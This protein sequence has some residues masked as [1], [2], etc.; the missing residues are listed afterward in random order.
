MAARR[1]SHFCFFN[2]SKAVKESALLLFTLSVAFAAFGKPSAPIGLLVNGVSNPLAIDRD[3]TRFTWMS[4]DTDRGERQTAYE[5]VVFRSPQSTVHSPESQKDL[6]LGTRDS[7]LIWWDSGRVDSDKSAAV[8]YTGK[9]LPATTRFW[10]KVRIWDQTGEAGNFSEAN[11]F[12]TG[13]NQD[14]WRAKYIW[15]GTTNRNNYA[16][17]RKTFVVTNQP[18]LA[19]VYVMAHND[20]LLYL[21]G[22]PLGRG[23]ARCDPYHYGQYNG[24]DVTSLLKTGTNV[25]AAMGHWRNAWNNAGVDAEPTF[26]LEARFDYSD[27]SF[28]TIG[29][30]ESWKALAHTA[31]DETNPTNSSSNPWAR[32]VQFDSR[33]EPHGWKTTSFDDSGWAPATVVDRSNYHLFAQMAPMEREQAA[34][35]PVGITRTNG[36]WLVDFGRCIDGWP[37]LTMRSNRPG[38]VVHIDYFQMTGERRI[39]GWDEYT[40][41]GGAET[42]DADFGR[43]TSFQVLKISGYAG[44]LRASDVRGM[45]AYCDADVEGRFRC[46]SDLLNDIYKMCERSAR[47]NIQQG[48]IS[49]DANREQAPWL[50]DSWNI[51]NVLLYN[52]R[53]TVMIDKVV[54]DYAGEQFSNGYFSACSPGSRRGEYPNPGHESRRIPEWHMYWPMLLW[55]QYLFSGDETLLREMAPHLARGMEWIKPSQDPESKLLNPPGWRIS[56]Y[57]GGNMPDG[58]FNAATACQYYDDLLIASKVFS[59]LGQTNQSDDYLQQAEQVKDGINAHLFN[60]EYYLARTDTEK[61]FPLASA[62]ALRFD[63]EPEADESKI[64]NSI[65]KA[66]T[67]NIGGYGGDAFYSG[68]F[69]A[70]GG[71]FA[72]KDLNR[73]RPML[74]E[75][76]ACWEGFQLVRG[77]QPNHA[78][79]SYPAYIFPKYILGIQPT[80]GGFATFDVRPETGGLSFAEGAVPTVKGL[81][82]TRWERGNDGDFL[83]K[84]NVPANTRA[85]IYIPKLS[86][87]SS[88]ITES[89]KRIWPAEAEI[90]DA[91]VLAVS[92]KDGSIKCVVGGGEYHFKERAKGF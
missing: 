92:N 73:Y 59:V 18:D 31:F 1:V 12:D 84:V 69:N 28:S 65:E 38:D 82:T 76:K 29:T 86:G 61:M 14:E 67:P 5:I 41:H 48:I 66:G 58:G 46:S 60:G 37:K 90:H 21:N 64:L 85:S 13:L 56:D 16:Y 2:I 27:G 24:Y 45:W 71:T 3:A 57:A 74:E 50:A 23:P 15:D 54:R 72:I 42:W 10:W 47:Q 55:Q 11:Y 25:F 8:E 26:L 17:F 35:K 22:Q 68:L 53:D 81:I 19:K 77:Y 7:G 40:C 44:K 32:S 30:D 4:T 52:D 88:T 79:T 63:I 89:G 6:G 80:S 49:V 62:W 39:A 78:W 70:G 33:I 91:G 20:Y 51:G 9:P 87:G 75:D 83:L 36:A 34:L 43:H